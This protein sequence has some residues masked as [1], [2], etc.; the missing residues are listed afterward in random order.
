MSFH[1]DPR[2]QVRIG[3]YLFKWTFLASIVGVCAGTAS[4]AFLLSLE[5][6]TE[7]RLEHRVRIRLSPLEPISSR[8][9]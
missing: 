9:R 4:A 7:T 1:W 3:R 2:E 5:F 8:A 6:A